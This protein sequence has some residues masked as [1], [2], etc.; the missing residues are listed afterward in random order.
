MKKLLTAK[1][2][3]ESREE[4]EESLGITLNSLGSAGWQAFLS[5]L[6]GGFAEFAVKTFQAISGALTIAGAAAC[7]SAVGS[8][9]V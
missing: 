2:A 8:C 1:V 4:R 5:E 7:R 3:K 6:R 9:M